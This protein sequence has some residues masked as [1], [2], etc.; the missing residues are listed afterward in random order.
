[1]AGYL[2]AST[3]EPPE[4]F[5]MDSRGSNGC[6]GSEPAGPVES[7]GRRRGSTIE[8]GRPPAGTLEP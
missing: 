6:G 8:A 5:G 7:H 1:M 2:V 4:D 3:N